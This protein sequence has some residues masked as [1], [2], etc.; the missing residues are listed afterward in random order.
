MAYPIRNLRFVLTQRLIRRHNAGF[1]YF[2]QK[3]H[4]RN[5]VNATTR[6]ASCCAVH[7]EYN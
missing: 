4:I 5:R 2:V 7:H 6:V 1:H 3:Q